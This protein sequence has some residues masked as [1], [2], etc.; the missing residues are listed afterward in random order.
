MKHYKDIYE[1]LDALRKRP[2]MYLGN[3]GKKS[4]TALVAFVSALGVVEVDAGDPCFWRFSRW[5]TGRVCGMSP[6]LPWDWMDEEW[7]NEQAF[8][9]FFELLD[10]YRTCKSVCLS[11]AILR[12]HEPTFYY[13]K[14]IDGELL[15]PGKPL[16]VCIAQFAPS[17]VY[18]LLEVYVGRQ[19]EYFPYQKSIDEVKE[20]AKSRWRVSEDEWFDL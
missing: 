14:S 20:L 7:G 19:E 2:A 8:D 18:Y 17:E 11:R 10:E 4:F 1:L 13:R 12:E 3:T 5:I 6:T 9:K 15:K 16:E